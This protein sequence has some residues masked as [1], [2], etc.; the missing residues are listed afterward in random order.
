MEGRAR[1]AQA[2]LGSDVG[3]WEPFEFQAG[4]LSNEY[5]YVYTL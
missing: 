1:D 5:L 3:V 4:K 2:E